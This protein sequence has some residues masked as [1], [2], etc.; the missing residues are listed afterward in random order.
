MHVNGLRSARRRAAVIRDND[1]KACSGAVSAIVNEHHPAS[2]DVSLGEMHDRRSGL[3]RKRNK[4]IPRGG[5][6]IGE[7]IGRVVRIDG[8]DV[9][10]G[11][12]DGPSPLDR[13]VEITGEPWRDVTKLSAQVG[14]HFHGKLPI[15][16]MAIHGAGTADANQVLDKNLALNGTGDISLVGFQRSVESPPL[17]DQ[18]RLGCKLSL[19]EAMN[20]HLAAITDLALDDCIFLDNRF[21]CHLSCP[22]QAIDRGDDGARRP[23]CAHHR[24]WRRNAAIE[25][26]LVEKK[27]FENA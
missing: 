5:H 7:V 14:A 1:I 6:R 22:L 24:R 16:H 9:L 15:A 12:D 23:G 25:I 10:G 27:G 21:A 4:S 26:R 20:L 17:V 3:T 13:D 8:R 11:D 2:L 19:D 18:H